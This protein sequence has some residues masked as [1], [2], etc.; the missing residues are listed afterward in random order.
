MKALKLLMICCIFLGCVAQRPTPRITFE[1]ADAYPEGVAF[2][3]V[4]N[5]YYVSSARLGTV[6]KVTPQGTYSVLHAD[7]SLK[8]TYGLKVHPDGKHVVV[9]V[10]DANYSKYTHPSTRT[11][12]AKLI[13]IDTETGKKTMEVDLSTLLP[14]KHFVNDLTFDAQGNMYLTDSYAHAIY[15]VTPD[16]KASVFAKDKRFETMGIGL[17]GIVYHPNGYLLVDNTNTGQ[18]YKVDISQ[19]SNIQKVKIDQYFLGA[20]GML[21]DDPSHLTIVV[22]GGNDKIY[23]L[24]STDNW[25]SA[26]LNASTLLA[27]RF[28]YPSTATRFQN[29]TWVMN[30]KFN[31]LVDSNSVPSIKFA[32][33]KAVL[34]PLPKPKN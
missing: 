10:G 14:G 2:D 28:T 27:D 22:N 6:G 17:N 23:R 13:S 19:P 1:A 15:K 26:V 32:I 3:S 21:L 20:D 34:K 33:Q 4:K 24:E 29:E 18:I 8:S 12:L 9:C 11:K 5:V 16:A 25:Q 31:E 7:S 30:A